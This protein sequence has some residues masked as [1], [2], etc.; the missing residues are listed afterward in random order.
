MLGAAGHTIRLMSPEYVRPYVKANRNDDHDA[1]AI[2]EAATRPTMR[3]VPVKSEPQS[4]IQALHRARSSI[5]EI[6]ILVN[7]ADNAGANG[8][9]RSF[10]DNIVREPLNPVDQWRAIERLVALAWTEEAVAVALALTPRRV[11]QLRLFAND[12]P[13]CP[14]RW[15]R[16]IC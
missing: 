14:T 6:D 11:K 15:P 10:A 5:E 1:E 8:A 7:D 3:F 2:A 16:A 13:R 12:C 4:D 9:I